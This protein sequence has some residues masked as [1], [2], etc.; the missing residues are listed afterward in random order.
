VV[1]FHRPT[2]PAAPWAW[3]RDQSLRLNTDHVELPQFCDA[4]AQF[5]GVTVASIDEHQIAREA[6]LTGPLDLL[7]RNL[8][9]GLE[10]DLLGM[11]ALHRRSLS[12]A[13]SLGRYNR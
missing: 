12:S 4:G 13:Q 10:A 7:E 2:H 5:G 11:P 8:R 3:L 9:L 1:K 6:R